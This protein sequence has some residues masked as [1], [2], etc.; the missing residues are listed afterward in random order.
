[1]FTVGGTVIY[2]GNGG[3]TIFGVIQ[4]IKGDKVYLKINNRDEL[5][6]MPYKSLEVII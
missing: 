4:H 2:R 3:N 5:V 1:M 6:V